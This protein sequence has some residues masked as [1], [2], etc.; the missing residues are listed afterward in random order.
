MSIEIRIPKTAKDLRIRHNKV[1]NDLVIVKNPSLS[2][3]ILFLSE[4]TGVPMYELKKLYP[5]N[6]NKLYR[7]SVRALSQLDIN[8]S[9]PQV[10]SLDG[11]EFELVDPHK[12][13][14]GWHIDFSGTDISKDPVKVACLFYFPKGEKYGETD[15]N[16]NLIN[17]IKDR[18][19]LFQD[20]MELGTFLE[21]SAFFLQKFALSIKLREIQRRGEIVG[22]RWNEKIR[23][24]FGRR[25]FMLWRKSTR[26]EIGGK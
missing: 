19:E 5:S 26:T 16:G 4:F 24:L 14:S 15:E 20:H 10:I 22:Q 25:L 23:S 2:D 1:L 3:E 17:P 6:I 13:A 18:Y 7:L 21:A 11:K 9:P 12:V 8:P